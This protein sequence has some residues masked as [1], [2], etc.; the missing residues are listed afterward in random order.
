M[1]ATAADSISNGVK[2][3]SVNDVSKNDSPPDESL[4][5]EWSAKWG[6]PLQDVYKI[7]LKFFKE[8]EGKALQLT[9]KTKLHLVALT[10]QAAFGKFRPGVSP[11]VGFLDVVGNDRRS[12]RGYTV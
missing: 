2:D 1:A 10:K 5:D 4:P 12:V 3:M 8:K 11:D 9:Y 6:F 7:A